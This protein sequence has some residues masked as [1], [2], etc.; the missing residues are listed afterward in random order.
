VGTKSNVRIVGLFCGLQRLHTLAGCRWGMTFCPEFPVS[1]SLTKALPLF[2]R[3]VSPNVHVFVGMHGPY[4]RTIVYSRPNCEWL[5][6]CVPRAGRFVSHAVPSLGRRVWRCTV[7]AQAYKSF[8]PRHGYLT[9]VGAGAVGPAPG[10]FSTPGMP[11]VSAVHAD[12]NF[13]NLVCAAAQGRPPYAK[14]MHSRVR[15]CRRAR[16][17]GD[18]FARALACTCR[19]PCMMCMCVSTWGV[20]IQERFLSTRSLVQIEVASARTFLDAV[21]MLND[22]VPLEAA[23][24]HRS[25]G[26][27]TR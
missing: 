4:P 21:M 25:L 3:L 24:E 2:W 26:P 10:G 16:A 1:L 13:D 22:G 7:L 27:S 9:C 8:F 5:S 18:A 6:L 12:I 23:G 11:T 15:V 19:T 17:C 14:P 20:A